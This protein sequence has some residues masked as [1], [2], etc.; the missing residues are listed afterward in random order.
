MVTPNNEE[1]RYLGSPRGTGIDFETATS[2]QTFHVL[3]KV[4]LERKEHRKHSQ[5]CRKSV[6]TKGEKKKSGVV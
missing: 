1:R 5:R 6:C 4:R 2:K 3:R